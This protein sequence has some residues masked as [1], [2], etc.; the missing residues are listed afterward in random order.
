MSELYTNNQHGARR[1]RTRRRSKLPAML[2]ILLIAAGLLTFGILFMRDHLLLG[3][4]AA[5]AAKNGQF[6]IDFEELSELC[7]NSVRAFQAE[8]S[9]LLALHDAAEENPEYRREIEFLAAHISAYSQDAVNAAIISPEKTSFVLLEP[10]AE[11]TYGDVKLDPSETE[12]VP[13][14]LQY[15]SRWAFHPYGSSV[16]G[17]TA[18]GPTCLSMAAIGVTGDGR[19]DPV[20]ISDFAEKAGYYVWGTGTSWLLFTDGAA[21]LG[22]TGVIIPCDEATMRARLDAG[23]VL[24]ASMTAGD[25]TK[26]GQFI[27]IHSYTGAGFRIYDPSSVE[28]SEERWSFSR[29]QSQMAQLWSISG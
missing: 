17:Y 20:Y 5:S 19:Y 24:I 3:T 29:L 13:F 7:A 11:R 14:L 2:F 9:D 18:C 21:V 1:A 28:R 12:G 16:M 6:D 23:E 22:L 8:E 4:P 10:F 25:F 27:V 26:S 15:D